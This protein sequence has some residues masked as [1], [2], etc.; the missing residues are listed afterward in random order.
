MN[1]L[2]LFIF[3]LSLIPLLFDDVLICFII[4]LKYLIILLFFKSLI[5]FFK[6]D[7]ICSISASLFFLIYNLLS[8]INLNQIIKRKMEY[9]HNS[10]F[11]P[12]DCPK[13]K[14]SP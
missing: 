6:L 8:L 13:S 11:N 14:D 1:I 2:L 9:D 3:I 4:L 12:F 5:Y 7:S 10:E